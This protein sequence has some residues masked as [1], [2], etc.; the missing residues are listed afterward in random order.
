MKSAKLWTGI[1]LLTLLCCASFAFGASPQHN[2]SAYVGAGLNLPASLLTFAFAPG[3]NLQHSKPQNSGWGGGGNGG[4]GG[5]GQG[6]NGGNNGWGGSGNG[7]GGWGGGGNGGSGGCGVPEGGS[8]VG[9]LMIGALACIG[10]MAYR[11]RRQNVMS[12]VQ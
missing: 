7:G 12:E 2:Q 6:G 1:V 11:A 10:A 8:P 3:G 4:G 5:C 9:Y